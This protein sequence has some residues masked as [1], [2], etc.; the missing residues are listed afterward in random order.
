MGN[1]IQFLRGSCGLCVAFGIWLTLPG[2][3]PHA[4]AGVVV[5][6]EDLPLE[7][8]SYYNGSDSAGGFLSEGAFFNNTYTD[9]GGGYYAWFGW[10]Y[11]N[12]TDTATPGWE[13]QYSAITGEGA[14]GSSNYGVAYTFSPGEAYIE[15]PPLTAPQSVR[16]TNTTY[17]YYTIRDGDAFADPFGGPTGDEPD[18]F[19]LTITGLDQQGAPLGSVD[20]Y[21]ADYRFEDSLLDYIVDT[22]TEVDLSSLA[23]AHTLSLGLESS[24][25][26]PYGMNTP[27]YFALDNLALVPEP[28]ALTLFAVG[29]LA[30]TRPRSRASLGKIVR[31]ATRRLGSTRGHGQWCGMPTLASEGHRLAE[32]CGR[33]RGHGTRRERN[34]AP[35]RRGRGHGPRLCSAILCT[36]VGTLTQPTRADE[37][38]ASAMIDYSPA[39]GQ[40]VN[41]DNFNDPSVALGPPAAGGFDVPGVSSL[42][43]L[44]GFGGS[45]TLAF[46]ATVE[47][48]PLNPFGMDAV[49]FGNAFFLGSNPDVHWAECA[50]IEISLD[51][52]G[53]GLPDGPPEE[54]W[55]LIP[56]SHIGDPAGQFTVVTW[57]DDI[58]DDTYPPEDASWIPPGYSGTWTTQAHALPV[59]LFGPPAV[60]NPSEDSEVEGIFGYAEYSPTL[61]LGD[62]DGDNVVDDP[63]VAPEDFYTVA[64]DP[65][66]VGIT[67]GSGG[68]DAFDIA[69]AID[70]TTGT[71]ARLTGFD[72]IRLTSAV[73]AVSELFGEKS[74][75]I[76]AVAD[77]SPD[78]FGDFD[79]DGDIDLLDA[80]GLQTCFSPEGAL[81]PGCGSFDRNGDDVVDLTDAAICLGR[82]TGPMR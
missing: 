49:V 2:V 63:D 75:E 81:N 82:M 52:N 4:Q 55:Q 47:D 72:F 54:P 71:P 74:P 28:T 33:E 37:P 16:I 1:R 57:D 60:T 19:L 11:S 36:A 25:V 80:A 69:W 70:P 35:A 67:P 20:F 66:T 44:G 8:E 27:A 34:L 77:V 38:F 10:S 3:L 73:N 53:N 42:V 39:P 76:D 58:A 5:G 56:G 7:P 45:I 6:F 23:G 17:A 65:L 51:A 46:T 32:R 31:P 61:K 29:A 40:F 21:L 68:G 30:L 62:L 59:D 26:G 64:D 13:N 18:Y 14:E 50:T 78:P 15:L 48:H 12:M 9:Y 24:D 79:E 41:D 43:T 22:W